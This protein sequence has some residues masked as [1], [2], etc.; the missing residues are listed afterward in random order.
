[1]Y[2]ANFL[3]IYQP[4]TQKEIWVRRITQE[5]Y[6]KIFSGLLKI[7]RARLTL[8]ING[9][10]CELLKKY[11]GTDVIDNIRQ[12]LASGNIELTGSAQYHAFLPLLPKSE[13]KRQIL[14]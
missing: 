7:K 3:H 1:M 2:W 4:P 13:I 12:L 9:I 8:N 14:L 6:R 5:S 11:G 10:L